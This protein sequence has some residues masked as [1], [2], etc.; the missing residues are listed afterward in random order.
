MAETGAVSYRGEAETG[1]IHKKEML[2]RGEDFG[3]AQVVESD[4][5][6]GRFGRFFERKVRGIAREEGEGAELP[7]G[8][9]EVDS[10]GSAHIQLQQ[11]DLEATAIGF[12]EA[13]LGCP[14]MVE[15]GVGFG[16]TVDG[17]PLFWGELRL[18]VF[19]GDG[20]DGF[21][22]DADAACRAE[23]TNYPVARMGNVKIR[24]PGDIGLVLW[25]ILEPVKIGCSAC[26][27]EG[28]AEQVFTQEVGMRIFPAPVA[29]DLW[30]Q[31]G[32]Q[33]AEQAAETFVRQ[34]LEKF[35]GIE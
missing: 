3:G 8:A 25:R 23:Q 10:C 4:G 5:G 32:G 19:E 33:P 21:D 6:F 30:L 26:F 18:K 11:R 29:E 14:E 22:V 27:F 17:C 7:G 31:H 34:G 9:V 20:V 16:R 15:G 28:E 35:G 2:N 13:F 12:D 24:R 1:G